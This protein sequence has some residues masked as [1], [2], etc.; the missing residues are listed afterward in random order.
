MRRDQRLDSILSAALRVL[1][2][3]GMHGAT[4]REVAREA[5]TSLANLYTYVGG[6]DELLYRA[7]L[8]V[9]DAA[10]ASALATA[11]VPGPRERLR[12][13]VTDHVRRVLAQPAEA[14]VLRGT[15]GL[16]RGERARR[17]DEQRR[18]YLQQVQQAAD[19]VAGRVPPARSDE[20]ARLLLG[21]ADRLALDA[22]EASDASPERLATA[23]LRMFLEGSREAAG[24]RPQRGASPG[25]ARGSRRSP[26][27]SG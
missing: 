20:R 21:M 8:R 11:S 3:H 18:R 15:P 9:L 22:L 6:R 1:T 13:L 14:E 12:A 25:S 7:H 26:S 17:V 4:M 10:V 23:V 2:R 27:P 19:A 5:R 24:S 16:L